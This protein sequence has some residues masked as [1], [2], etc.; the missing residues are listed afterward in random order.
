M[1]HCFI[2]NSNQYADLHVREMLNHYSLEG[3]CLAQLKTESVSSRQ[4]HFI[5]IYQLPSTKHG[6]KPWRHPKDNQNQCP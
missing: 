4:L 1:L 6:A 5:K 2:D 3:E